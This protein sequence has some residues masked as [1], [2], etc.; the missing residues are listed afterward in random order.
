M[1]YGK[2]N[3]VKLKNTVSKLRAWNYS[4]NTIKTY[5]S[6]LV[7]M[8]EYFKCDSFRINFSQL[9]NYL[10]SIESVSYYNQILSAYIVYNRINDKRKIPDLIKN[11]PR[12]EKTVP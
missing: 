11:R 5:I 2:F 4:E 6:V 8:F 3:T 7:K 1:Y 10:N 9:E 12:R